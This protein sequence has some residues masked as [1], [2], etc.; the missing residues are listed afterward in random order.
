[1][2]DHS[3]MF[4]TNQFLNVTP[5][6]T[7]IPDERERASS[8]EALIFGSERRPAGSKRNCG[9]KNKILVVDD[10]VFNI[11]TLQCI[12]TAGYKLESDKA[13]NGEEAVE[14]VNDR[15]LCPHCEGNY[16]LIFMDCNMPVMDGFQATTDI[17]RCY[18]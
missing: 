3:V 9:H 12:L 10:N 17:R 5:A 7:H 14:A 15:R 2:K 13:L 18:S 8:F 4:N 16:D 11:M 1:M 6:L